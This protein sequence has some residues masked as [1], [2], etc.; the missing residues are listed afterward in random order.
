LGGE[1]VGEALLKPHTCYLP[2]IKAAKAAGVTSNG[3]AHITGGG[4]I[5]NVPRILPKTVDVVFQPAQIENHIPI[6]DFLVKLG[7][8]PVQ[9]AYRVFNMGVGMVW[10]VRPGDVQKAI[11]AAKTA[12][13]GA[14]VC[15]EVVPGSGKSI[16]AE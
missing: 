6:F 1:S 4:L 9:E 13:I 2:A 15:G 5:D 10:F 12:G 7:N 3:I 14:F 16:V 11:D 8:L